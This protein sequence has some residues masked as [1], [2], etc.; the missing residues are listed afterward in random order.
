MFSSKKS[1]NFFG[2][3]SSD[4]IDPVRQLVLAVR[5]GRKMLGKDV[6]AFLDR[7]DKAFRDLAFG[8]TSQKGVDRVLP[9][10]LIDLGSNPA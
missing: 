10:E 2:T 3:C 4:Q 1:S 5:L 7:D 8:G 6:P 9:D